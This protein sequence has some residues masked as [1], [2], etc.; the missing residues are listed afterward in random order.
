VEGLSSRSDEKNV[1]SFGIVSRQEEKGSLA[2][3]KPLS[4]KNFS[5]DLPLFSYQ[6]EALHRHQ[7]ARGP[8]VR[9]AFLVSL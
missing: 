6:V 3:N 5:R 2:R 1:L 7:N 8:F 4:Q 9:K